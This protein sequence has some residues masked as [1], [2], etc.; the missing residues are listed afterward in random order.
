MQQH[1]RQPD[2]YEVREWLNEVVE[3]KTPP[4]EPQEIRDRLWQNLER[5][6]AGR[7]S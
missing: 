4:P 5:E 7:L 1:Y 3:S 2:K 6:R